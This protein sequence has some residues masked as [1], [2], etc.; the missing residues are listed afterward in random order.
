MSQEKV[1]TMELTEAELKL[2]K[3]A[4]NKRVGTFNMRV[5]EREEAFLDALQKEIDPDGSKFEGRTDF[6]LHMAEAVAKIVKSQLKL[7]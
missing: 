1:T 2:I 4:R 6:V 3:K 5:S 7:V